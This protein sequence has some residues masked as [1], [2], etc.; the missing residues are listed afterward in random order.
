MTV[1]TTNTEMIYSENTILALSIA[2]GTALATCASLLLLQL[3]SIS[4]QILSP[5][6]LRSKRRSTVLYKLTKTITH[7]S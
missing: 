2:A 6:R 7:S 3:D 1:P 4:R 5:P